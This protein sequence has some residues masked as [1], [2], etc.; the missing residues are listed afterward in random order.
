[1]QV[2]VA[3]LGGLELAYES[4]G[5]CLL[6]VAYVSATCLYLLYRLCLSAIVLVGKAYIALVWVVVRSSDDRQD[7][8][9]ALRIK[10]L[11]LER[12]HALDNLEEKVNKHAFKS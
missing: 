11:G 9:L 4:M 8:G 3:I 2:V 12:Q 6:G 7:V 5:D 10:T 1:M